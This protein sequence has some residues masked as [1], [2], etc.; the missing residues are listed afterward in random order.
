M[1]KQSFVF[2]T[3]LLLAIVNV[4]ALVLEN[5]LVLH[6]PE[7]FQLND[8]ESLTPEVAEFINYLNQNFNVKITDYNDEELTLFYEDFPRYQHLILFPSSKKSIKAKQALNQHN[9]LQF[10]NE[11]G[12]VFVIGGSKGV[13]PDGIRGVLNEVG[14]YPSPKNYQYI[15]HFNSKDGVVQ[16]SQENVVKGN[17]LVE[18]LSTVAYEGNAALISNNEYIFPIIRSSATGYTNKVGESV[19]AETTWTF[20]EQGY[21]AVGLQ[22]L[23]NARLVWIGSS[24][25]LAEPSLYKWGLQ[26]QGKLKLQF[27]QHIK[28]DEPGNLNPHLYRIK[29][30]AIYSIGVSELV[31]GKWVPFQVKNDDEQLQLAFKMLD[32]YQ[33]LNLRPL[34]PVSSQEGND[35]ELDTYAYYIEF[36]VPDHHGMFTF[37]L[38]YK[39]QGL[40]YLLDKR[41]VTVR[42]LAN[43]EFKRSW[44]ISNSWLYIASTILV[45]IAWYFFI[46]SYIYVGKPNQT[47]KN[48]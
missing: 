45:I 3:C 23:N 5:A 48:E 28:A 13:L 2:L 22:A 34:G 35:T 42:H 21:L 24:S 10:I 26:Q 36:T 14:I 8:P 32:P 9:L 40:S 18:S 46:I 6:D 17:K 7:L 12:N 11:E 30:Q 39:R 43:D 33:R 16:L 29:D 47:K 44:D 19:N 25:L 31:D 4:S 1:F 27:V 38:D 20:G 15:D 37:E 41:V